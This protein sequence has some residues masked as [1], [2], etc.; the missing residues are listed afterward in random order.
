MKTINGKLI[1]LKSLPL[2]IRRVFK[3]LEK[4]TYKNKQTG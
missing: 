4:W 2:K 3:H 1:P